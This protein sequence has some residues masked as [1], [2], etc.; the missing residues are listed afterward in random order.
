MESR[1]E[2]HLNWQE[3]AQLSS[4]EPAVW[5]GLLHREVLYDLGGG[6]SSLKKWATLPAD[7]SRKTVK[8][9]L[10]TCMGKFSIPSLNF[11]KNMEAEFKAT[12][13]LVDI[14]YQK[15]WFRGKGT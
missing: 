10:L 7:L 4:L 9:D 5:L 1:W 2:F 11:P 13:K 3:S 6:Q 15:K 8:S 14:T 12:N